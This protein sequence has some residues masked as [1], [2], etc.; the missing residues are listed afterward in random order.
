MFSGWAFI[1]SL[2]APGKEPDFFLVRNLGVEETPLYLPPEW[3]YHEED[4]K[5]DS[6]VTDGSGSKTTGK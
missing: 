4:S 6:K 2:G 3:F 5:R 1:C